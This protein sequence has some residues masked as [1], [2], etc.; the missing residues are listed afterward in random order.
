MAETFIGRDKAHV[1]GITLDGVVDVAADAHALETFA[2]GVGAP[3]PVIVGDDHRAYQE[4][5]FHE[6]LA[7]AEYIHV[8]GDA[9]VLTHLILLYIDRRDD[10]DDFGM[11]LQLPEHTELAVGPES[12]QNAACVIIVEKFSSQLEVELVPKLSYALFNVF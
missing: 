3:L 8:V 5:A 11:F 7:Q 6:S 12:R 10:D 2:V 1:V 9:E 4:S